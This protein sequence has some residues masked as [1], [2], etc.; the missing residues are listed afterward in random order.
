MNKTLAIAS[1]H[2]GY[3]MKLSIITYLEEQG[4]V[5]E[6]FGTDSSDAV[7]YPDFGHPLAEAIESGKFTLGISLCGTGNGINMVTNKHQ[8]I[9]GAL[10]WNKEISTLARSHNDANICSIPARFIDLETARDIVD[11]FLETDY[12]GGRHDIRI[13]HIPLQK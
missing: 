5:V 4:Y 11:A 8:K 2:A 7:N 9:R 6:D 12:E 3:H 10:C 1:D 13:S